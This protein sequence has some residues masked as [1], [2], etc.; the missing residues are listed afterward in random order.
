MDCCAVEGQVVV[1]CYLYDVAPAC[2]D[3]RAGVLVVEDFAVGI[4][5]AVTIDILVC[6]VE[7]ILNLIRRSHH[8]QNR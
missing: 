5:D 1:H 7:V 3:P 2:L 4:V 6:H 8:K